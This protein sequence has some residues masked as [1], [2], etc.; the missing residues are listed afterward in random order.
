ML[1]VQGLLSTVPALLKSSDV[2]TQRFAHWV[3]ANMAANPRTQS[4]FI[5]NRGAGIFMCVTF[6]LS[7]PSSAPCHS[8]EPVSLAMS[9][10]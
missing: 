3:L 6:T 7:C 10:D 4:F 8:L 2:Q 5:D 1:V 9:N